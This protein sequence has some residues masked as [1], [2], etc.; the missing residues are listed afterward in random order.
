VVVDSLAVAVPLMVFVL[1]TEGV[2]IRPLAFARYSHLRAV[3]W[4]GWL[5]RSLAVGGVRG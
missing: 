5:R 2:S 1:L 3:S 4:R